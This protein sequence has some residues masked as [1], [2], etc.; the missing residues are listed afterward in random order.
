METPSY[1]ALA[2]QDA[3]RRQMDVIANNVANMNTTGFKAQRMQ[4][5]EFLERASQSERYSMPI[6]LATTRDNR[7][8]P[9]TPTGNPLDVAIE[10]DAYFVVDTANGPRY[11]RAG[12]FRLDS[13]RRIVDKSGLPVLNQANQPMTIPATASEIT[14]SEAGMVSTELGQVGRFRM[15]RFNGDQQL[16]EVG[17][18]LYATDQQATAADDAKVVQGMLEGSNVQGVVEMTS[19][20]SVT[21]EYQQVQKMIEAEHERMRTANRQLSRLSGV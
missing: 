9:V 2:R 13:Q 12:Q 21:R 3:L 8:G 20:I 6:D 17:N 5:V 11:T 1:I 7:P 14:I 16:E 10:G 19:M 18:G 4:F 15:V